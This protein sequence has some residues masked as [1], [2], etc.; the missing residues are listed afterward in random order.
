MARRGIARKNNAAVFSFKNV[1][2]VAAIAIAPLTRAPMFDAKR[3]NV[4]LVGE[5]CD[6]LFFVPMQ[7]A[8]VVESR[9]V[10]EI[11]GPQRRDHCGRNGQYNAACAYQNDR[12]ARGK[13]ARCRSLAARERSVRAR[14]GVWVQA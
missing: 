13:E 12:N 11:T 9:P 3:R 8:H 4:D 7:F 5:S 2:V 1:A 10:E 14:S 6:R